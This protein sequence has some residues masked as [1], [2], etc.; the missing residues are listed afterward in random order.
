MLMLVSV[1]VG[2]DLKRGEE[3]V[4]PVCNRDEDCFDS[5]IDVVVVVV[6]CVVGNTGMIFDGITCRGTD[7]SAD[8]DVDIDVDIDVACREALE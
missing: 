6:D 7:S 8:V 4:M 1:S 5:S 2:V 3:A